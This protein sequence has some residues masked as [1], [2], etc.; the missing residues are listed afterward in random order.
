MQT[1]SR[2]ASPPQAHDLSLYALAQARAGDVKQACEAACKGCPGPGEEGGCETR[3][4]PKAVAGRADWPVCPYG[5]L[6]TPTWRDITD[7]YISTKISPLAG[8]PDCLTAGAYRGLLELNDA[9][10]NE[11][12][13]K[14]K[15]ASKAPGGPQ[16]NGRRAARGPTAGGNS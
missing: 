11:D 8:F 14:A 2:K 4:W 5:M 16:F 7:T 13:R 10:R 3:K 15:E 12:V 6:R 1:A 9:V